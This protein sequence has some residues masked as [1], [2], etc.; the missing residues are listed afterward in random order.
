MPRKKRR[1]TPYTSEHLTVYGRNAVSSAIASGKIE[2]LFISPKRKDDILLRKA[3]EQGIEYGYMDDNKLGD[4]CH[5]GLHQG[6]VALCPS[7]PMLSLEKL[8]SITKSKDP[9]FLILDGIQDPANLGSLLRSSDAFGADGIIIKS[10]GASPVNETVAKVSTGAYNYVPVAQVG[11]LSQAIAT[12]KSK[13]FWIVAS[14]MKGKTPYQD[15]DYS[16]KMAI[17]I[18]SEG[19]GISRLVLAN[20]DFVA[21]IEMLGHVNSL[22]AAVAGAL[23]LAQAALSRNK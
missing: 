3:I 1:Y 18:G 10:K 2:H 8:L 21:R 16:G 17:V 4:L 13:G 7:V 11:N 19:F 22:N 23:F 15:I 6:F 9:L 20:C 14:D 5:S 12:L